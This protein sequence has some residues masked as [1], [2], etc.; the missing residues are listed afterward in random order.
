MTKVVIMSA[1]LADSGDSA[2]SGAS[3][4]SAVLAVSATLV[5]L[6]VSVA[7]EVSVAL[8]VSVVLE[9]ATELCEEMKTW[10]TRLAKWGPTTITKPSTRVVVLSAVELL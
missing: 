7:S 9:D 6:V 3:E 1:V 10:T 5:V 8:V 2:T 4:V